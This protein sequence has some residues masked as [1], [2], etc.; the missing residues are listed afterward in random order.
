[1]NTTRLTADQKFLLKTARE[2]ETRI[3]T[4]DL[5]GAT[6]EQLQVAADWHRSRAARKR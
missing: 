1:M 3:A 5:R 4:G 2:L 6:V